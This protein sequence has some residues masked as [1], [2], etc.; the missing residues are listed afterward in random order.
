LWAQFDKDNSGTLQKNE[1]RTFVQYMM[2]DMGCEFEE[3]QFEECFKELDSNN[4]G[5]IEKSEMANF[6]K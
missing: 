3:S 1:A 6:I 2:K 4:D 5:T